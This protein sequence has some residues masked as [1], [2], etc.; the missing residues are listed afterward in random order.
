MLNL[1]SRRLCTPAILAA[2]AG[3][4]CASETLPVDRITLY[5]SGVGYFERS[6]TVVDDARMQLRVDKD[7]VNDLLKSLVLLDLDGGRIDGATYGSRDPLDRRLAGFMVDIS[8]NPDMATLLDRLR[9]SRVRVTLT[10]REIE[11][12]I[13]GV[14]ERRVSDGNGGT[15]TKPHVNIL[16]RRGIRSVNLAAAMEVDILDEDLARELERALAV[17]AEHRSEKSRTLELAFRGDGER[18]VHVSYVLETPVWK[19]SYRLVLPDD[20]PSEP[21][22]EE[23]MTLQGWAIVENTT[24]DDWEE[25]DLA[26]VAGQPV[27]FTMDLYEPLFL[28]RP[29]LPVPV[30]AGVTPKSPQEPEVERRTLRD[31]ARRMRE[32]GMAREAESLS[33]PIVTGDQ[34]ARYAAQARAEGVDVGEMFQYRIDGPVSIERQQSAMLPIL[35][36][37]VEG[38]RVSLF[39]ANDGQPRPWRAVDLKNTT[40]I[41][42]V[43]GPVSVFDAGAYGGDAQIEQLGP[44]GRTMLTYALD[45]DLDVSASSPSTSERVESFRIVGGTLERLSKRVRTTEYRAHNRDQR[46]GRALVIQHQRASGW[47][48]VEPSPDEESAGRLATFSLDLDMGERKSLTVREERVDRR[49]LSVVETDLSMLVRYSRDGRV[50]ED[51]IEAVREASRLNDR[52]QE[53][54]RRIASLR[55]ERES[56]GQDQ[57]RIREN[58]RALDRTSD[59]YARY[60]R[61]LDQQETRLDEIRHELAEAQA[62]RDERREALADF[63]R[64]LNVR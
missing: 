26:L 5:R 64:N 30:I 2:C 61:T 55:E 24:D 16:T 59:L 31:D 32:R 57:S 51:V 17:L 46:R 10:D 4:A 35:T 3:L 9:G 8:D 19:T 53:S 36:G 45:L 23:T 52:V 12:T 44:E 28:E 48:L 41:P 21:G 42:F 14:E 11:G 15:V 33:A 50:S 58:M 18:R 63:L 60:T 62:E 54:E 20:A 43:A 37:A 6:G 22:A 7:Q 29:E 27:A 56:I 47:D 39:N 40:D 34:L 49:E 13:V 25:V 38:R 1:V